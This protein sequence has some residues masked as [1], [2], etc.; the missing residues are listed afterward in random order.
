ASAARRSRRRKSSVRLSARSRSS[1]GASASGELLSRPRYR[2]QTHFRAVH[3]DQ[4]GH[5]GDRPDQANREGAGRARRAGC[6]WL[7]SCGGAGRP[8]VRRYLWRRQHSERRGLK[9]SPEYRNV[10]LRADRQAWWLAGLSRLSSSDAAL[11]LSSKEIERN[12]L[13]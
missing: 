8:V 11:P 9:K 12:T 7:W 3:G 6:A 1:L 5:R 10:M 2:G 13:S 4:V